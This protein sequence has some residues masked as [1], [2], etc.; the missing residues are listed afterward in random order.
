MAQL[1]CMNPA[2]HAVTYVQSKKQLTPSVL[3]PV[4]IF[5]RAPNT[6]YR[7]V[8]NRSS[9]V[10]CRSS[11]D[12]PQIEPKSTLPSSTSIGPADR[13]LGPSGTVQPRSTPDRAQDDDF[14]QLDFD[15]HRG[16]KFRPIVCAYACF[17][18]AASTE[19]RTQNQAYGAHRLN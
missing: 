15:R 14:A 11:P 18:N 12:R 6:Y 19:D 13:S 16:S 4:A 10:D 7:K 1:A 2:G 8:Y 5:A 17:S 3:K 9:P